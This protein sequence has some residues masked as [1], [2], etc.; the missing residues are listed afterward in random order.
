MDK[1]T[2]LICL[3]LLS[4]LH[5]SC[6]EDKTVDRET[7]DPEW[8]G[9][10]NVDTLK[11]T[12]GIR[13]IFQDRK[14]DHW[15]GSH[16]E[17]VCHY[18]GM[19]FEYFTVQDGL[20]G[21]QVRSI[22]EDG[23]GT[24]WFETSDGVSSY[25]GKTIQT[26]QMNENGNPGGEWRKSD[27]DLWF[28]AGTKEGVWRYDGKE[29]NYLA[30]PKPKTI[31]AGNVYSLTSMSKGKNDMLWFGT[32]AGVI[33]Y[34]GHQF[35]TINDETLG[36]M[37]GSDKVHVRSILEDSQGRLWIGNNGIGVMLKKDDSIIHFSKVQGKS[38]PMNAFE[39]NTQNRTF[40][41][42]T[43][44][45]AVFAIEEDSDG[46]IWFGDRDSGAWKYDG[47]TLTNYRIDAASKSQMIWSIYEDR[48]KNLLFGMAE[49]GVY[50]FNGKSFDRWL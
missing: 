11:F 25:D 16:N 27:M 3:I 44:L 50:K 46:N 33:G 21:N 29:W 31:T 28:N 12:S 15:F 6:A 42:N 24:I 36:L 7:H 39:A 20:A 38:I 19:S 10:L 9:D 49:G 37:A 32:Y 4:A 26:H 22:Q 40:T 14:G 43:G 41:K 48:N 35:T 8:V 17:G 23:N 30:F 45:Q 5:Y 13:A 1:R 34:N 2:R 18:N 47:T